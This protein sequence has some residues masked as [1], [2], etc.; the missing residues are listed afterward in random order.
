MYTNKQEK[1]KGQQLH[2]KNKQKSH[3]RRVGWG[4]TIVD[5]REGENEHGLDHYQKH[6]AHPDHAG[7]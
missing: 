5:D 4:V 6:T 1:T 2:P 7:Q 3:G